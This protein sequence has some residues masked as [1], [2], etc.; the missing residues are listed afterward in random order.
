MA[1]IFKDKYY[2]QGSFL[3]STIGKK[4]SYAWKR[5]W[6]AKDFIHNGLIWHV[7]DES[8][9]RIWE[10]KWL[11]HPIPHAASSPIQNWDRHARVKDLINAD[12]GWWNGYLIRETFTTE[13]A[14]E[15]CSLPICPTRLPDK[16]IWCGTSNVGL[17]VKSAYHM[18]KKLSV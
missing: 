11:S 18:G 5:I 15:I 13:E 2:P 1:Q 16:L 4:P 7:G 10:A 8:S 12:T 3:E 14:E 6:Q 17:S 9:I